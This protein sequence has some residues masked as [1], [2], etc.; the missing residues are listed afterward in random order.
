[1]K[2]K[3]LLLEDIEADIKNEI[4]SMLQSSEEDDEERRIRR[5]IGKDG[6]TRKAIEEITKCNL[7]IKD[8][9]VSVVGPYEN[10]QLIHEALE[11]LIKGSSH[12][13]FY[14]YLERNK[15]AQA[16]GLL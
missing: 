12:K 15:S 7:S 3:L 13:S 9:F 8:S 5:I 2:V 11:M 1:M 6:S 10:V 14:S 4:Q 16:S